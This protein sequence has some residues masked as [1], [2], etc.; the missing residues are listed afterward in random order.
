[1]VPG[2]ETVALALQEPA[3]VALVEDEATVL[4]EAGRNFSTHYAHLI[5]PKKIID[6]SSAKR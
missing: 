4:P 3:D 5:E 6:R 2:K 1:M